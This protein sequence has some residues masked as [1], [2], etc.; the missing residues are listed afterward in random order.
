M[1]LEPKVTAT[2]VSNIAMTI[3]P[4]YSRESIERSS[5]SK[6]YPSKYVSDDV[7]ERMSLPA[8]GIV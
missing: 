6:K 4:T 3:D 5:K 1:E 2:P 7:P 8:T